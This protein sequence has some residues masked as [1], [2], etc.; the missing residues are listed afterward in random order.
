MSV[1]AAD[2]LAGNRWEVV[3]PQGPASSQAGMAESRR[4]MVMTFDSGWQRPKVRG[5]DTEHEEC[6]ADDPWSI[7]PSVVTLHIRA[8]RK[9]RWTR[10]Q[11]QLS[12]HCNRHC[13]ESLKTC[14]NAPSGQLRRRAPKVWPCCEE[15]CFS[16]LQR[17]LLRDRDRTTS[18]VLVREMRSDILP[19]VDRAAAAF[20]AMVSNRQLTTSA[21]S[22]GTLRRSDSSL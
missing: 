17:C 22:L 6:S 5:S 20:A 14:L 18:D 4:E 16:K 1:R 7:P 15:G 19:F 8:S 2:R 21:M 3:R 12:E 10:K 11:R 13:S 9:T